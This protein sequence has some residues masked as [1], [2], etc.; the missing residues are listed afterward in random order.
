MR[1]RAR[2]C[3]ERRCMPRTIGGVK[4]SF[5]VAYQFMIARTIEST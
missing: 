4:S 1:A 3:A 5:L 2:A